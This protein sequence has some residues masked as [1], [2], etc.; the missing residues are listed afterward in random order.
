MLAY[1][2][3]ADDTPGETGHVGFCYG[4][5]SENTGNNSVGDYVY[6][7][8]GAIEKDYSETKIKSCIVRQVRG[9]PH[10]LFQWKSVCMTGLRADDLV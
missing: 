8:A 6:W 2:A 7:P 10:L 5:D 1:F 3:F 9:F 4:E